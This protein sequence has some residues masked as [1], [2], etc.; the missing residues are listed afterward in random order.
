MLKMEKIGMK[1]FQRIVQQIAEENGTTPDNVL[2]EMELALDEIYEHHKGKRPTPEE[3]VFE[4]AMMLHGGDGMF[5]WR[6]N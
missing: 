5:R 6:Q 3:F 2:R 4:I 1:D